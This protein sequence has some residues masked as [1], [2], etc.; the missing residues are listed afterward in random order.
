M[1][2]ILKKIMNNSFENNNETNNDT[3]NETNNDINNETNNK[4]NKTNPDIISPDNPIIN[5]IKYYFILGLGCLKKNIDEYHNDY[6]KDFFNPKLIKRESITVICSGINA[7]LYTIFKRLIYLPP[8]SD[9]KYLLEIQNRIIDD[10]KNNNKVIVYGHSYGGSILS[11]IAENLNI[12]NDNKDLYKNLQ[13]YTS[14]SI[15]IPKESL[16]N[17]NIIHFIRNSDIA[18]RLSK[19]DYYN[20]LIYRELKYYKSKTVILP[21]KF[22][23]NSNKIIS[24]IVK[25]NISNINRQLCFISIYLD[26]TK[27]FENIKRFLPFTIKKEWAT[28]NKYFHLIYNILN[29]INTREYFNKVLNTDNLYTLKKYINYINTPKDKEK[30]KNICKTK[31]KY[32]SICDNKIIKEPINKNKFN[33][34][35]I[36]KINSII[37]PQLKAIKLDNKTMNLLIQTII[38][39]YILVKNIFKNNIEYYN[40]LCVNN[41]ITKFVSEKKS[42]K[43]LTLKDYILQNKDNIKIDFIRNCLNHTF[44]I[45]DKLYQDIQFHYCN[46][47]CEQLIIFNNNSDNNSDN[48]FDNIKCTLSNLDKVTFTMNINNNPYRIRLTKDKKIN[49]LKG[50]LLSG[51]SKI[52]L[53][54]QIIDMQYQATPKKSNLLEKIIFISS[55]CILINSFNKATY[56]REIMLNEIF[57]KYE[58]KISKDHYKNI[59]KLDKYYSTFKPFSSFFKSNVSLPISLS[60]LLK[61][62]DYNYLK[63]LDEVKEL[64]DNTNELKSVINLDNDKI[65]IK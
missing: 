3:N 59:I 10:L 54:N 39:K 45:L 43:Y 30:C 13:M 49:T 55:S 14:A 51:L 28:H 6:Y 53:L 48:K 47:I 29:S 15:Y 7:A 26:N 27:N 4:S 57:N 64:L 18:L 37:N 62:V 12:I 44:E 24:T 32:L 17:V 38:K 25:Y 8:T 31:D 40:I 52:D 65:I 22:K 19:T 16:N 42:N 1:N 34:K 5:N 46:P 20:N 50:K 56:L 60:T 58:I 41:G 2:N 21:I 36:E 35:R 63:K 23:S 9:S 11:T 61:Y 33:S